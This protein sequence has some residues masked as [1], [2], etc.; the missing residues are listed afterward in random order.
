LAGVETREVTPED[1]RER[2]LYQHDEVVPAYE[3][4]ANTRQF[5]RIIASLSRR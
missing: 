5:E 3:A 4:L 1:R 2:L